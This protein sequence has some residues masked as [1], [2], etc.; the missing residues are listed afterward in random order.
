MPIFKKGFKES[1]RYDIA[2][3]VEEGISGLDHTIE[4]MNDYYIDNKELTSTGKKYLIDLLGSIKKFKS[5]L[6]G[7]G[8]RIR[9]NT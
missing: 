3:D 6:K 1:H 5:K 2:R 9:N 7:A 8:K 4:R